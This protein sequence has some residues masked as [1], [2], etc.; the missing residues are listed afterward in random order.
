LLPNNN[1]QNFTQQPLIAPTIQ[2][3]QPPAPVQPPTLHIHYVDGLNPNGD[4]FLSLREG[5]N[6][7]STEL[8]RMTSGTLL[9]VLEYQG[10]WAYVKLL[11]EGITGWARSKWIKCCTN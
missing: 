10:D 6:K 4:N 5:P 2:N 7:K 9:Q 3:V 11:E 8:Y 1:E